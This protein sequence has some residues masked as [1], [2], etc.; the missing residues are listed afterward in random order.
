MVTTLR[1]TAWLAS[2]SKGVVLLCFL[3]ITLGL[4]TPSAFA[5]APV[6]PATGSAGNLLALSTLKHVTELGTFTFGGIAMVSLEVGWT[7]TDQLQRTSD[8]G[9]TWQTVA[10]SSPGQ[11]MGPVEVWDA[12][13]AWF[14]FNDSQT[15]APTALFRTN[16]GGQSWTR[17]AWIDPSQQLETMSVVNGQAAWVDTMDA[18]GVFHLYLVGAS[19]QTW[20]AVTSPGPLGANTIYFISPTVGCAAVAN[21]DGSSSLFVTHDGAKTWTPLQLPLP[22]GVPATAALLNIR[23][24]GFATPEIGYLEATFEDPTTLNIFPA[25]IYRT[26]DGGRSWQPDGGAEPQNSLMVQLDLWHATPQFIVLVINGGDELARLS[27]GTW[28][29]QQVMWPDTSVVLLSFFT[30]RVM[31]VSDFTPDGSAQDL[32]RTQDGRATWQHIATLPIT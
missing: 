31:F 24:P 13:T 32:F 30:Q 27:L 7:F 21:P 4:A 25:Q 12:Q 23:F 8:G 3:C 15:F 11:Y 1:K 19:G 16:D 14:L 5:R 20:Q 18:A 17:F 28:T 6:R 9:K 22:A 26:L 2:T 29:T 10:Q